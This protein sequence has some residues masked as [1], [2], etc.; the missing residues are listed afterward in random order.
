MIATTTENGYSA[1]RT[2]PAPVQP[3]SNETAT[4]YFRR[5]CRANLLDTKDAWLYLRHHDADLPFAVKPRSAKAH[6]ARLGGLPLDYFS[7]SSSDA[8]C[9]HDPSYWI[10]RCEYCRTGGVATPLCRRCVGG[11]LAF[12]Y[13]QAGPICVKHRRWHA[14]ELDVDVAHL[15]SQIRAQR[16]LDR[17]L[18]LRQIGYRSPAATIARDLLFEWHTT[19]D[20]EAGELSPSVQIDSFPMLVDLMLRL[21]STEI[22]AILQ[23]RRIPRATLSRVL[24][25]VAADVRRNQPLTRTIARLRNG[26]ALEAPARPMSL[27]RVLRSA[28]F[29]DIDAPARHLMARIP[30]VRAALLRHRDILAGHEGEVVRTHARRSRRERFG[31][32]SH[33]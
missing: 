10:R 14:G 27:T 20:R 13:I 5:L 19:G 15:E 23:D 18:S 11:E 2:L 21:S 33:T 25:I 1:V 16:R 3:V 6:I 28:R 9:K 7:S 12:A 8:S 30:T 24:Q 17:V 29:G 26:D 32:A 4:S 22:T 31:P